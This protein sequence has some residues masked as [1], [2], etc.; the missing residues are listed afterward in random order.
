VV[1]FGFDA[2]NFEITQK[3]DHRDQLFVWWHLPE[4]NG[5]H[6]DFQ[7]DSGSFINN[8]KLYISII[9]NKLQIDLTRHYAKKLSKK[10]TIFTQAIITI[11][12]TSPRKSLLDLHIHY[13]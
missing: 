1:Y 3:A 7:I 12:N 5:G 2:W 8:W 6:T 13:T 9:I 11:I 10:Y 4:S